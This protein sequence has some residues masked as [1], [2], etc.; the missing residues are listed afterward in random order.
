MY[1]VLFHCA[2]VLHVKVHPET[3]FWLIGQKQKTKTQF[4]TSRPDLQHF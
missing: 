4:I 2:G 1:Y 3:V